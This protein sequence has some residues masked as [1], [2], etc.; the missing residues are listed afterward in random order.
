MYGATT[1]DLNVYIQLGD[2]LPNTP[3][4]SRSGQIG[5]IWVQGR[6]NIDA[7]EPFIVS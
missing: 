5:D 3:Y 1:G 2:E 6:I 7:D 4:W